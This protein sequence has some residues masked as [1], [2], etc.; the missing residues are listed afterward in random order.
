[1]RWIRETGGLLR[2]AVCLRQESGILCVDTFRLPSQKGRFAVVLVV[3]QIQNKL[4]KEA[5]RGRSSKSLRYEELEIKTS[6][7]EIFN[8]WPR[9]VGVNRWPL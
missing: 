3:V 7:E 9:G 8:W 6:C 1:M 5:K 2:P 4:L